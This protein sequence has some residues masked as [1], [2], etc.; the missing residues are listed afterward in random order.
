M[1]VVPITLHLESQLIVA[2]TN[3][4]GDAGTSLDGYLVSNLARQA[5]PVRGIEADHQ[6]LIASFS[7]LALRMRDEG[8]FDE[9]FILN[10]FR[11]AVSAPRMRAAYEAAIEGDAY[12]PHLPGKFLLN[13]S[14]GWHIR[15]AVGAAPKRDANGIEMRRQ[16]TGEPIDSYTLLEM[17]RVKVDA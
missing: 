16:V 1:T 4:A 3:S 10:V 15:N 5:R 6:D 13:M 11:T 14:L 17:A 12:A 7:L 8:R 9:H 2:L